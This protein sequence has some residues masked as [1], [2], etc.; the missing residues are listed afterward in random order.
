VAVCIGPGVRGQCWVFFLNSFPTLLYIV[1]KQSLNSTRLAAQSSEGPPAPPHPTLPPPQHPH[2]QPITLPSTPPT[3]ALPHPSTTPGKHCDHRRSS[4]PH[5]VTP[6][7]LLMELS[8]QELKEIFLKD[9]LGK[10]RKELLGFESSF[11]SK[12]DSN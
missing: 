1:V 8:H 9:F 10:C 5:A 3:P 2:P 7:T 4:E 11:F 12:K 6:S